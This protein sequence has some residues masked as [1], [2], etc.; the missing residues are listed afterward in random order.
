MI[1]ISECESH[2]D[3]SVNLMALMISGTVRLS[4]HDVGSKMV[5]LMHD[6]SVVLYH[7]DDSYI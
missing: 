4:V 2:T 7:I 1:D 3:T 6:V 5:I